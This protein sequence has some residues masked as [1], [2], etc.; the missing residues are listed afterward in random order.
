MTHTTFH[1]LF[2][3]NVLYNVFTVIWTNEI[4]N[5]G[6]NNCPVSPTPSGM[7]K[8]IHLMNKHILLPCDIFLNYS[9]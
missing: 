4:L 7:S 1:K 3:K 9:Y 6:G 5:L 8:I 2:F